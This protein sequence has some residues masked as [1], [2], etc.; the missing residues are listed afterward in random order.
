[1]DQSAGSGAEWQQAWTRLL[2]FRQHLPEHYEIHERYI[3]E[4]Q[5]LL[6]TFQN[7]TGRDL[8]AF[9]VPENEIRP[10]L[11]AASYRRPGH[12][13]YSSDNYC[14]R[15]IFLIK[16]DALIPFIE[17]TAQRQPLSPESMGFTPRLN[18]SAVHCIATVTTNRQ[19]SRLTSALSQK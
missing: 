12:T 8:G 19:P 1:M 10:R 7:L 14:E 11:V 5:G 17:T 4:Y 18:A 2:A 6:K 16:I 9:S 3:G 13:Q 15:T